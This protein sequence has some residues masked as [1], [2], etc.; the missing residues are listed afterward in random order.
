MEDVEET[1][2]LE[3][4]ELQKYMKKTEKGMSDGENSIRRSNP[5]VYRMHLLQ[6]SVNGM[7]IVRTRE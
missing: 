5:H 3:S 7:S 6:Y 4:R 1:K 2:L